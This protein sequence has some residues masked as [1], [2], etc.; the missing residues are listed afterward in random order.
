[1]R[2]PPESGLLFTVDTV[3]R[4]AYTVF[5]MSRVIQRVLR[6]GIGE[7]ESKAAGRSKL[8]FL[9]FPLSLGPPSN[10]DQSAVPRT[11][12]VFKLIQTISNLF[13]VRNLQKPPAG[14]APTCI[15]L[16]QLAAKDFLA[17]KPRLV[18]ARFASLIGMR[19]ATVKA[20]YG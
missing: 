11:G 19:S 13:K 6:R 5:G 16:H 14:L 8:L 20:G 2:S 1:M 15:K 7:G 10:P 9:G 12:T 3:N 4:Y 17:S 18:R